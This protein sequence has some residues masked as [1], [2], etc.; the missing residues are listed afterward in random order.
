MGLMFDGTETKRTS[1]DFSTETKTTKL[2]MEGSSV[3]KLKGHKL[4]F[5]IDEK[6]SDKT[7]Y[8]GFNGT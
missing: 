5:H 6:E 4:T 1:I 7:V 3:H 2:V 8:E